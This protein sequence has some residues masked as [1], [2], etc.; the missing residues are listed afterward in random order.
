MRRV[1]TRVIQQF[2]FHDLK[3][4]ERTREELYACVAQIDQNAD[5]F[6]M[7]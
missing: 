2:C 4:S 3:R 7:A 5:V 1:C 6:H